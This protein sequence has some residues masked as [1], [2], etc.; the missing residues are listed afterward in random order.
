M[1]N[2]KWT[3]GPWNVKYAHNG[4]TAIYPANS[5]ERVADIFCPLDVKGSHQANAA[6]I[7]AAPEMAEALQ[8]TLDCLRGSR[9]ITAE[10]KQAAI[11]QA[12]TALRKA[13]G[14]T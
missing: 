6:L 2:P 9:V 4:H 12:T 1:S 13:R 8:E 11:N 7:A 10:I 14:E 5:Q 3:P